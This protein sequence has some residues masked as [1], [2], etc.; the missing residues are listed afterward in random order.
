M[1]QQLDIN[2]ALCLTDVYLYILCLMKNGKQPLQRLYRIQDVFS[3]RGLKA[4]M[5]NPTLLEP[6][7]VRHTTYNLSLCPEQEQ[8]LTAP[9]KAW[10]GV[11]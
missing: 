9:R 11:T 10:T 5:M 3:S 2:T 8:A 4:N 1:T 7:K 6:S